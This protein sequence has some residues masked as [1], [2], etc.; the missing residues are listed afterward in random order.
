MHTLKDSIY[1]GVFCSDINQCHMRLS[2]KVL[3]FTIVIFSFLSYSGTET[4]RLF[5][6]QGGTSAVQQH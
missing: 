6:S 4:N 3:G 5:F 1:K 2:Y